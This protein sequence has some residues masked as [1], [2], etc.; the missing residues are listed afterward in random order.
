VSR[1]SPVSADFP[2]VEGVE[3]RYV[4]AGGLRVHLVEAGP[5]DAPPVLLLNGWPQAW[6]M[7]RRVIDGL[8]AEFRLLAAELRGFGA[9]EAPGGGYDG[10][11]FA[12]DQ[13]A[14][15]D[16]LGIERADVV[17]HDWGGW[18]AFLLG[19]RHPGRVGR[20]L[21]CNAPHP[22]IPASLRFVLEAWRSWYALTLATPGLGPALLQRTAF[23]NGIL[24]RGNVGT[25]FTE[26][27]IEAYVDTF[28]PPARARGISAL[29][30]YY[31]RAF[32]DGARGRWRADRLEAPTLLL[33]GERD[34][35]VS[36]AFLPG[37]EPFADNMRLERVPDSGHFIVD[38]KP[39]LV[40]ERARELFR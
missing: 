16:A 6:W 18:T 8:R 20:L 31:W 21:V 1:V 37:F 17:G 32:A 34:L 39:G 36:A 26:A 7:W 3:H 19:V 2:A 35:Y 12:R 38:E 29:Y 23:A 30:R 9:T 28:R 15:L 10:E 14:L 40:V 4:D 5:Q 22:W 25:P 13:V 33:F 24:R 11:T 27:E